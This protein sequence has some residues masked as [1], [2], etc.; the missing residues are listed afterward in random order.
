MIDE[1]QSRS[2]LVCYLVNFTET[3][4]KQ[5]S[6]TRVGT[7]EKGNHQAEKIARCFDKNSVKS[8]CQLPVGYQKK[9]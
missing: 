6:T 1:L 7:R 3:Q 9:S 4:F 2:D 5:Y 8:S